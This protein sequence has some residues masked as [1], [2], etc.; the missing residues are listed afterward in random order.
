MGRTFNE[1][2]IE[3]H[4][5]RQEKYCSSGQFIAITPIIK[6]PGIGVPMIEM[7]VFYG[8]NLSIYAIASGTPAIALIE[9]G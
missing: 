5:I 9:I 3:A 8:Q 6:L 1:A 2:M 4:I 7:A